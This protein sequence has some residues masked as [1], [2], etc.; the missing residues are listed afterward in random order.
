MF[1]PHNLRSL[2]DHLRLPVEEVYLWQLEGFESQDAMDAWFLPSSNTAKPSKKPHALQ[3][4][5]RLIRQSGQLCQPRH[6]HGNP[7]T[8]TLH[9]PHRPPAQPQELAHARVQTVRARPPLWQ[10]ARRPD[11]EAQTTIMRLGIAFLI[12][13]SAI[14]A[15]YL[16]CAPAPVV[17]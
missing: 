9:R 3:A 7:P 8:Q 16:A 6:H 10:L 11:A 17:P 14:I 5:P 13:F 1:S 12:V 4:P 15:A 2:C